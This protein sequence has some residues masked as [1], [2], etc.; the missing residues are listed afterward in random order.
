MFFTVRFVTIQPR[1]FFD[2][3]DVVN[4]KRQY[5]VL[6]RQEASFTDFQAE[7]LGRWNQVDLDP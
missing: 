3:Y 6:D 1:A 2:E 4:M 7:R 5:V